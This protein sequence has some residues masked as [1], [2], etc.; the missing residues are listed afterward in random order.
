[1]CSS[2]QAG[3]ACY[4]RDV[5]V[6]LG[7]GSLIWRPGDLPVGDWR[8]DGPPVSVEFVRESEDG[9][10]TLVLDPNAVSVTSLW[11]PMTVTDLSTAV[12]ELAARERTGRSKIA[13]WS[14]GTED[15]EKLPGLREWAT[16]RE[17]HYVIWTAL[18]PKFRGTKDERPNLDQA[19]AHLRNLTDRKRVKAEQYVRRAPRQIRT[20]YRER[21][22]QSLGWTPYT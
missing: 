10:L 14:A 16:G 21:F 15:P 12:M 19:L 17:I 22:E 4:D 1:M 8:D 20:T 13:T 9:R 7:W 18:E 11:A 3:Y 6:C 5:I 2:P